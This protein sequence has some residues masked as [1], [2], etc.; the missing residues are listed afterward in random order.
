MRFVDDPTRHSCLGKEHCRGKAGRSRTYDKGSLFHGSLH[1][2]VPPAV[3]VFNH[4]MFADRLDGSRRL[5][6]EEWFQAK[7]TARMDVFRPWPR[8][9]KE[10]FVRPGS[11]GWP[12]RSAKSALGGPVQS[13]LRS[14]RM[15]NSISPEG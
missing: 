10:P 15:V 5:A 4:E 9:R 14:R 7:A 2:C 8:N 12:A 3:N 6:R 1:V 13:A 11:W